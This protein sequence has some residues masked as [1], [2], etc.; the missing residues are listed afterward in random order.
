VED[1]NVIV[2][3]SAPL[4]SRINLCGLNN[5]DRKPS[6]ILTDQAKLG[7]NL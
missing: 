1:T 3:I 7:F 2:A 6:D 5:D 4:A